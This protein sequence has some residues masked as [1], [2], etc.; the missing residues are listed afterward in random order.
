M[1]DAKFSNPLIVENDTHETADKLRTML[2]F[3][4]NAVLSDS[5][6]DKE[7]QYG[8]SMV[9]DACVGAA[10]FLAEKTHPFTPAAKA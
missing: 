7:G 3:L 8:C 4:S 5:V 9:L 6:N 2:Y 10:Q 1:A